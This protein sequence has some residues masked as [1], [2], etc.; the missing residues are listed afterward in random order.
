MGQAP[1]RGP[2]TID[3]L[4]AWADAERKIVVI[5]TA[6]AVVTVVGLAPA[7][8]A[9]L[10]GEVPSGGGFWDSALDVAD[11]LSESLGFP[12]S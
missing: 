9:G 4:P 6:D 7:D 10:V 5:E 11:A 12:N 1:N 3:G 8:V 2:T